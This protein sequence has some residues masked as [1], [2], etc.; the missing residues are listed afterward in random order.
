M[1]RQ[2]LIRQ[3]SLRSQLLAIALGMLAL[4]IVVVD[5]VTYSALDSFLTTRLNQQLSAAVQPATRIVLQAISGDTASPGEFGFL[6]NGS[7]T[8][9]VFN[10]GAGLIFSPQASSGSP[11][12]AFPNVTKTTSQNR[13]QAIVPLD[14]AVTVSSSRDSEALYRVLA[15][16]VSRLG[17][18][19][20][21][22]IPLHTLSDTLHRLVVVEIL[23]S[24]G[25]LLLLS[26][27]G[28]ALL[29]IGFRPLL[30][31]TETARAIASG[32]H[33][34]RVQASGTGTE[35]TQL[36][37][38]LNKM[39][40]Q[41]QGALATSRQSE[42]RLK[43]FIADASH[44]L[45]TPLTS[46]RGYAE[47]YRS[48]V[49]SEEVGLSNAMERIESEALRMASL[50]EDLLLLARLD[51]NRPLDLQPLNFSEVV[52]S[53]LQDARVVE[54]NRPIT[55]D[56]SEEM[57]VLGDQ[58]RLTQVVGNL[59]SNLRSHTAEDTKA[60]IKLLSIAK[61]NL[62]GAN[63]AVAEATSQIPF[64]EPDPTLRDYQWDNYVRLEVQD[65][66]PGLPEDQLSRVFERFFRSDSSRS[67]SQG[68]AGL[69]LSLVAAIAYAHGGRVWVRSEGTGL[70]ST[71]GVDLPRLQMTS[72]EE[73]S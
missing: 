54:P 69:G 7:F 49:V 71:F 1:I 31:M 64:G 52:N 47:L 67:R 63:L 2:A 30:D 16:P 5:L 43:R 42:D 17:G 60:N 28:G 51:Q 73:V 11:Q 56:I 41:I 36:A 8:E 46:I 37:D 26:S 48:G 12:A 45:R 21:I 24:L 70:G 53:A 6:P 10:N 13:I 50:I 38:S 27:V 65:W 39:L 68:G 18:V 19:L 72:D 61:D 44:E 9:F 20:I 3:I 40:S 29:R 23:V 34:R 66:G 22:A 4:G 58:N 59:F 14:K 33:E 62:N 57:W 32:D 25:A 55:A 35:V 15:V